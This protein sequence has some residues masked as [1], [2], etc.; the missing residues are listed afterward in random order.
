MKDVMNILKF[1][2]SILF[3]VIAA[4]A[5]YS[6]AP[7]LTPVVVAKVQEEKLNRTGS[8]VVNVI[9]LTRSTIVSEGMGLI[10]MF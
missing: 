6:Q 4:H 1:I 5:S 8:C 3:I 2:S 7:P 10:E 9:P